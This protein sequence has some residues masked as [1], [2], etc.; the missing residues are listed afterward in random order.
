[1]TNG[2]KYMRARAGQANE[3]VPAFQEIDRAR[4]RAH[5]YPYGQQ[6]MN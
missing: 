2:C 4:V 6:S 1:M 3:R 5:K